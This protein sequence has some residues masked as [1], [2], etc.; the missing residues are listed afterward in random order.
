MKCPHRE[1][2]DISY[3]KWKGVKE[4]MSKYGKEHNAH[5]LSEQPKPKI[6]KDNPNLKS[7][8]NAKNITKN[9]KIES[10]N[11]SKTSLTNA[12]IRVKRENL[13]S[14]TDD[15]NRSSNSANVKTGTQNTMS[16]TLRVQTSTSNYNSNHIQNAT[17]YSKAVRVGFNNSIRTLEKLKHSN[18]LG[19]A[20]IGKYAG[21][22]KYGIKTFKMSQLVTDVTLKKI[23]NLTDKLSGKGK[24]TKVE[25]ITR[26]TVKNKVPTFLK[27]LPKAGKMLGVK[28]GKFV[29]RTSVKIPVCA[30][31]QATEVMIHSDDLG[32]SSLGAGIKATELTLKT[33]KTVGTQAPKTIVKTA[34]TVVHTGKGVFRAGK[35]I[36]KATSFIKNKGLQAAF[37]EGRRRSAKALMRA[38]KKATDIMVNLVKSVMRKAFIPILLIAI[39]VVSFNSVLMAPITAVGAIFGGIFDAKDTEK[40]YDVGEYLKENIPI[41]M[42]AFYENIISQMDADKASPDIDIVRFRASNSQTEG[43]LVTTHTVE[44]IRAR[45]PSDAELVEMIQPLFNAVVLKDYELEPTE[46]Q[47]KTI[48]DNIINKMFVLQKEQTVEYCGQNIITGEGEPDVC[49][50]CGNIHA[51]SDCPHNTGRLY[52]SDY[53]CNRCDY[54]R[55]GGHRNGDE[56]D[57]CGGG[58]SC[59]HR[60]FRCHGH[61]DCAGHRVM[62]YTLNCDGIYSL[63]NEYFIDPI[64]SLSAISPRTEEQEEELQNLKDYYEIFE[65]MAKQFE[66]LTGYSGGLTEEDLN[67]VKFD[68][69]GDRTS[70]EE[71][72]SYA[73]T[74]MPSIGGQFAWSHLGF[75]GRVSWCACAVRT[76]I[77]GAGAGASFPYSSNDAYCPTIA[78]SFQT[79]HRWADRNYTNLVAGDVIYFDYKHEGEPHHTGLVIGVNKAEGKVYTIEGNSSDR[80][81]IKSYPI[82]SSVIYG[83][84]L[85]NY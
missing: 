60:V 21:T 82:G 53:T 70:N 71:L 10:S 43:G 72:I 11:I 85:M 38:G 84:G 15:V 63:V 57:Y 8:H 83:Y 68:E 59:S 55:C 52:H 50:S 16:A 27:K 78:K 29:L 54:Y 4:E 74:F 39:L 22:I 75:K 26:G 6:R 12:D 20:S 73:K 30:Y 46:E 1:D 80:V 45:M 77:D 51:H 37:R 7:E 17:I 28:T 18:D 32:T 76:W 58:E 31:K 40:E 48:L 41:K 34:K 9:T 14:L 65:E 13:E 47:A 79:A 69:S 81:K 19:T 36:A 56:I 5:K 44:A 67:G 35:G 25:D 49:S 64:D 42:Q 33:A 62:T 3:I 66:E 23:K 2:E 24:V 61:I